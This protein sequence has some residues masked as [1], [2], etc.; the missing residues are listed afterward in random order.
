[1]KQNAN[2]SKITCANQE[3][4]RDLRVKKLQSKARKRQIFV[5]DDK[6]TFEQK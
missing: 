2:E 5:R 6:K 3:L 1:V 4:K